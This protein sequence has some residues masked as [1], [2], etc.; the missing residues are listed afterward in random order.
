ME[1]IGPDKQEDTYNKIIGFYDFAEELIDTVDDKKTKDPV[2]Q[3]E[4]VEPVVMQ[5]EGATDILAEE[6]REF[7][8]TGK[9][10]NFLARRKVAKSLKNVYAAVDECKKAATK[11]I[12]TITPKLLSSA[13]K[14]MEDLS[15]IKR[16]FKASGILGPNTYKDVL[17]FMKTLKSQNKMNVNSKDDSARKR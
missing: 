15:F 13:K 6:Y 3:L 12:A 2:A 4:F 11:I 8:R 16:S 17:D 10:P 9:K 1:E 7:I 5:I 14:K